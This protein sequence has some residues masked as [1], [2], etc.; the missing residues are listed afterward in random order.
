MEEEN[1]KLAKWLSDELTPEELALFEAQPDFVL[2]QKIRYYSDRLQTSDFDGQPML[3]KVLAQE[4]QQQIRKPKTV[5]MG[6]WLGRIAAVLVI[7]FGMYF[8]FGT[9]SRQTQMTGNGKQVSFLL[10]DNSAVTLNSGSEISYKKWDWDNNRSLDLTGEAYFRVAKGKKFEVNTS[11]GKVTVLG[12][13]F[14][15][16]A[17][18]GRFDVSCF[19]GRV[20]VGYKGRQHLIG[21]GQSVAFEDNQKIIDQ[22]LTA[23]KP[24]WLMG[25]IVFE[26]AKLADVLEETQRVCNIRIEAKGIRSAQLFSGKI[27]ANSSDVA[28]TVI[29]STYH[30]RVIRISKNHYALEPE[31]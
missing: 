4:K 5:S 29:A 19:E 12:T 31:K 13:Q 24:Y 2:Y 17:R 22:E 11:L 9:F 7:G 25:Q 8:A 10:P 15:V 26:K 16:K 30:L 28:L 3:A 14:N 21:K 20:Q 6:I 27:P 23:E 1:Y 18:N